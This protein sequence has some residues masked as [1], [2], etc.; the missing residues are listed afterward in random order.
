M[1]KQ[2]AGNSHLHSEGDVHFTRVDVGELILR[3]LHIVGH[4]SAESAKQDNSFGGIGG[5]IKMNLEELFDDGLDDPP[6]LPPPF[7]S[8]PDSSSQPQSYTVSSAS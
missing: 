8:L 7:P 3:L 6:P 5:N 2:G 1:G 4:L